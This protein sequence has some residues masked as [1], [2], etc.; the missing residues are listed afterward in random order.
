MDTCEEA[1][2]PVITV[3]YKPSGGKYETYIGSDNFLGGQLAAKWALKNVLDGNE[4]PNIVFLNNP[5]SVAS[6]ERVNGFKDILE[7]EVPG[8]K[9]VAEQGETPEKLY[10]YYGRCP[11]G[12]RQ[13]D[14]VF[15]YSAD[16]GLGSYDAIQAAGRE[17]EVSASLDLMRQT[18]DSR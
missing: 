18:K 9:I 14:L 1:D 7:K 5:M 6:V 10:E 17:D 12:E 15:S 13:V 2:I 4:E 8:A 11:D 16:G 3:D